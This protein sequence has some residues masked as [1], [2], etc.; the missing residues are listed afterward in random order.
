[1]RRDARETHGARA[2]RVEQSRGG[3]D[4]RAVVE[5]GHKLYRARERAQRRLGDSRALVNSRA[6]ARRAR[7]KVARDFARAR[8]RVNQLVARTLPVREQA[9]DAAPVDAASRREQVVAR[10]PRDSA[11]LKLAFG[12]RFAFARVGARERE[13]RV[14]F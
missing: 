1:M 12:G 10:A 4:R 14:T 6:D 9:R 5:E 7:L 8:E 2:L 13:A 11:K 3:D